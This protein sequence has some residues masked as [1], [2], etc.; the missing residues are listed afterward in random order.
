VVAGP[1]NTSLICR[2]TII[3]LYIGATCQTIRDGTTSTI[4]IGVQVTAC[5]EGAAVTPDL[6]VSQHP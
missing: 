6:E 1:S 3:D 4:L 2:N 5:F